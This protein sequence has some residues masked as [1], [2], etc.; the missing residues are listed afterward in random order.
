[1]SSKEATASYVEQASHIYSLF[2]DAYASANQR[3]LEYAKSLWAISSK[4]YSTSDVQVAVQ[5][6]FDRANQVVS[7]SVAQLQ[8]NGQ[9]SAEFAEKL[10]ADLAKLQESYT[11]SLKGLVDTGI[12]NIN[13]V[14]DTATAQFEDFTKRV[15]DIQ[16]TAVSAN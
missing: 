4:P 14:K 7:L 8:T 10:V 12:S 1:M 13:Y 9:K 6:G 2:V 5:E 11:Q 16:K 15:E 3:G